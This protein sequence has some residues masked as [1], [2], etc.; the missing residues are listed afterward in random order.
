MRAGT[1]PLIALGS[2]LTGVGCAPATS[3]TG[4]PAAAEK[5]EQPEK[6]ADPSGD[7]D[8][9]AHS[10]SASA[11]ASPW[12]A[13]IQDQVEFSDGAVLLVG[14]DRSQDESTI[15]AQP[16]RADGEAGGPPV[17]LHDAQGWVDSVSTVYDGKTVWVAWN[18]RTGEEQGLEAFAGFD[19]SLKPTVDAKT[20]RTY[21]GVVTERAGLSMVTRR[22][23]GSGLGIAAIA[24]TAT[25]T[26]MFGDEE[27][28]A[29]CNQLAVDIVQGDGTVAHS[30][31]A[32]LEGG[33]PSL[34]DLIATPNGVATAFHA[35]RG[36][37]LTSVLY[38]SLEGKLE[39]PKACSYPPID[40]AWA[41]G[42]LLSICPD[43]DAE[44]PGACSPPNPGG[45]GKAAFASIE[46]NKPG[47]NPSG[48]VP[49]TGWKY[50]CWKGTPMVRVAWQR[51]EVEARRDEV[52]A[53]P[54]EEGACKTASQGDAE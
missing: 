16:Q 40:L 26:G 5:S 10:P 41:S 42:G 11:S 38:L 39:E 49:I 21:S 19:R 35:W 52:T 18:G 27:G 8:N 51:G 47:Q 45:C 3:D 50:T 36:G 28:E 34:D 15:W 1:W 2:G 31:T 17:K 4:E 25:C 46:G 14:V 6:S 33:E 7:A 22:E 12:K 20:L 43:P 13:E 44:A 37:P 30:K 24:G 54:L 9:D 29:T 48:E 53:A 32:L 23:P